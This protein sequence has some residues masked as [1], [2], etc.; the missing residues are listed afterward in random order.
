MENKI[1][2]KVFNVDTKDT[3]DNTRGSRILDR[4]HEKP[5]VPEPE[6]TVDN[7]EYPPELEG[8]TY[9]FNMSIIHLGEVSPVILGST[10]QKAKDYVKRVNQIY[11]STL[12]DDSLALPYAEEMWIRASETI[13]VFVMGP[14]SEYRILRQILDDDSYLNKQEELLKDADQ[15]GSVIV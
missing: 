15:S 13:W 4:F 10:L 9:I 6:K 12:V 3:Q 14:K 8:V 2:D 7:I 1:E 5:A 11:N